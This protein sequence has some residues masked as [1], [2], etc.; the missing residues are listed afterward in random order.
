MKW[1]FLYVIARNKLVLSFW[2][3]IQLYISRVIKFLFN[4]IIP[5]LESI[6]RSKSKIELKFPPQDQY[7]QII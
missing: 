3:V 2:K 4:I 7:L 5:L 1:E 6:Q